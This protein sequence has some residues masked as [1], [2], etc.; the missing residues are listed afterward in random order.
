MGSEGLSTDEAGEI[1]MRAYRDF[2]KGH[3]WTAKVGFICYE[4]EVY[5]SFS[6]ARDELL[7]HFNQGELKTIP[8]IPDI[9][10]IPVH[11][12]SLSIFMNIFINPDVAF[13]LLQ[14]FTLDSA[15]NMTLVLLCN[16]QLRSYG[17]NDGL[18][19]RLVRL[20]FSQLRSY[21]PLKAFPI[22]PAMFNNPKWAIEEDFDKP[23]VSTL[24]KE[25][26]ETKMER[27]IFAGMSV[28]RGNIGTITHVDET[29]IDCFIFPTNP[30]LHNHH[31]GAA[32]AI[33]Q[34]AGWEL[35]VLIASEP[36][37]RR[38]HY[39]TTEA[40]VTPGFSSGADY[41]IHCIGPYFR[42]P[43]ASANLY[44]TYI[45]AL[46]E[47]RRVDAQC[48]VIASISTG[49]LGFP[50]DE[51]GE[52]AMR[53]YRDFIKGHRWTA[54]VGFICYEDE[55]YNS[56]SRARDELLDHFNEGALELMPHVPALEPP[57]LND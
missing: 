17:A 5:D 26:I 3:R 30:S 54:K 31:I 15:V 11:I 40:I 45:N 46:S 51:A 44:D 38:R 6:R 43:R 33:F 2:I 23:Q 16:K 22:I 56:F 50:I 29:P 39:R 13:N 20:H 28:F 36:Y 8:K 27:S 12:L 52:I 48:V 9:P 24:C 10:D 19:E 49:S 47:A 7:G 57:Q 14:M 35:D 21:V 41:L 53:A 42:M 37:S 18:W 32:A 55:V 1:A 25:F 4:D 34:R